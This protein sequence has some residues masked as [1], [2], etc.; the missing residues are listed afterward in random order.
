LKAIYLI[1][2]GQTEEEFVRNSLSP[3]LMSH[4]IHD[5][6][7]I[8]IETSPGF[9]GGDLKYSRFKPNVRKLLY[10]RNDVIVSSLIDYFRLRNDFPE[11][12]NSQKFLNPVA[13]V[14]NL[15]KACAMDINDD[16]F[17][18][19]IQLFEFEG[20][21]FSE[22]KGFNFL[23]TIPQLNIIQLQSI[24]TNYPNPELIND[25][26]ETA[27]SKRLQRLIPGY[28][29]TLHGPVIALE[30]GVNSI[31][32]KC[33]RFSTWVTALINKAK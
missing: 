19:Y 1:V 8:K 23:G 9:K 27:P 25:G 2:E 12:D 7:A 14:T 21:L 28:K 13:R 30:N 17:L 5:V 6:R 33:P 4:G 18:P 3:Y 22:D 31:L 24:I 15:E 26:S 29:K 20:L 11:Y 32:S 16:R 10:Q